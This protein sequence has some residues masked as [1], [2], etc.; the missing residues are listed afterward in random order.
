MHHLA[1]PQVQCLVLFLE[2]EY[3]VQVEQFLQN[4]KLSHNLPE[5]K[6]TYLTPDRGQR[7]SNKILVY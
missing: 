2:L 1:S 7:Q 3:D 6:Q 4:N 5:V